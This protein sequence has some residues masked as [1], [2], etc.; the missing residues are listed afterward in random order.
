MSYKRDVMFKNFLKYSYYVTYISIIIGVIPLILS[1]I[2]SAFGNPYYTKMGIVDNINALAV[3]LDNWN[4][5]RMTMLANV[6]KSALHLFFLF[7]C[8]KLNLPH[9]PYFILYSLYDILY[10][11]IYHMTDVGSIWI[12]PFLSVIPGLLYFKYLISD[13]G[14]IEGNRNLKMYAISCIL[15]EVVR[16]IALFYQCAEMTYTWSLFF[17][18]DLFYMIAAIYALVIW[19]K[20]YYAYSKNFE[21][22]EEA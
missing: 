22:T 14:C 3:F 18:K 11:S 19:K 16:S 9:M 1:F 17:F 2:V 8:S 13:V 6:L 10:F 12:A 5:A 4:G 15:Y 7:K 21:K 20:L